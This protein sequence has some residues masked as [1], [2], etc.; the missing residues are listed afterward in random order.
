M[1][2]RFKIFFVIV[3]SAFTLPGCSGLSKDDVC[4]DCEGDKEKK[5]RTGYDVCKV[6]PYCSVKMLKKCK[7]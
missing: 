1:M 7:P 3:L 2:P 6:A 5:C 4:G